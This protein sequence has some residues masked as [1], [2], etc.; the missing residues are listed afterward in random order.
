M[1]ISKSSIG[2]RETQVEYDN[3]TFIAYIRLK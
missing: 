1:A 2:I 3:A